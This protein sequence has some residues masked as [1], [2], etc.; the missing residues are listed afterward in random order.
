MIVFPVKAQKPAAEQADITLINGNRISGVLYLNIN[1]SVLLVRPS[2]GINIQVPVNIVKTIHFIPVSK[3]SVLPFM[4]L[5]YFNNTSLGISMGNN[6]QSEGF[7]GTLTA[8]MVNGIKIL[9]YLQAGAGIGID[10]FDRASVVSYFLS[11]RGDLFKTQITPFY[12]VEAG[13][14]A[15]W[16]NGY[17][18]Y[19]YPY[20]SDNTDAEGKKMFSFGLGYRFYLMN[21]INTGISVGFKTQQVKYYSSYDMSAS[22]IS[23]ITYH[24]VNFRMEFGF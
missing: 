12:F 21:T 9:P 19:Y 20:V 11:V 15:A 24:R 17:S 5:R 16:L 1:D 6:P 14:S 10:Q 3:K 13:T 4:K 8:D 2:S 18:S 22:T 23:N 7:S